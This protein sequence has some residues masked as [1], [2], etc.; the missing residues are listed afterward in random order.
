M[1]MTVEEFL[2]L[3]GERIVFPPG[4]I[5]PPVFQIDSNSQEKWRIQ[6][7]KWHCTKQRQEQ[8]DPSNT[9]YSRYGWAGRRIIAIELFSLSCISVFC[10]SR[11]DI[12]YAYSVSEVGAEAPELS[13]DTFLP[14]RHLV[15]VG[16]SKTHLSQI[17]MTILRASADEVGGTDHLSREWLAT[18]TP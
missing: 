7:K 4:L 3:V 14:N 2:R 10:L 8:G 9:D 16:A 6:R 18:T 15:I 11:S 1:M 17:M 13:Q 12:S 5:L